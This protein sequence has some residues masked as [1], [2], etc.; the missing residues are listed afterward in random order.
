MPCPAPFSRHGAARR[1][2]RARAALR[3]SLDGGVLLLK[4][5]AEAYDQVFRFQ[6]EPNFYYLTGWSEP[7]AA[8]LL[9]PSDEI[10]FLPSHNEHAERY[11]GKRTSAEDADAHAVTGFEN[12]LPIEKLEARARSGARAP[13]RA[14][15]RRGPNLMPASCDRAILSARSPTPRR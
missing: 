4:G 14:S 8:L 10:L 6:Q 2:S 1:V 12:V 7:G 13:I 11:A 3:Q 9:T 15:T 5:Q